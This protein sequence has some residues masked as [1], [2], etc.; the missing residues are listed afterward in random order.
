MSVKAA[1]CTPCPGVRRV[2]AADAL[3]RAG[4][5][6]ACG[7]IGSERGRIE[8]NSRSELRLLCEIA[9]SIAAT[10]SDIEI[11]RCIEVLR[12]R[13]RSQFVHNTDNYQEA[14]KHGCT[15]LRKSVNG[16]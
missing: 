2:C 3:V 5:P 16:L 4:V 13:I 1:P 7:P 15:E 12:G 6:A 11:V 10:C 9:E 14:S 8:L